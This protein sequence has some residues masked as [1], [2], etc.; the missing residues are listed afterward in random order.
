MSSARN[1]YYGRHLRAKL[2]APPDL[3]TNAGFNRFFAEAAALPSGSGDPRSLAQLCV[4]TLRDIVSKETTSDAVK[5]NTIFRIFDRLGGKAMVHVESNGTSVNMTF[6]EEQ[7]QALFIAD[8]TYADKIIEAEHHAL[9]AI[10]D[11]RDEPGDARLHGVAR[12]VDPETA[13]G[14]TEPEDGEAGP[15]G[16]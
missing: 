12:D 9:R 6:V 15:E 2:E 16:D 7:R 14:G 1:P 3:T 11:R 8:P 5:T 10:G 4:D 13:L